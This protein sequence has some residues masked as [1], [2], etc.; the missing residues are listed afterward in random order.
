MQD[1]SDFEALIL[2]CEALAQRSPGAYRRRVALLAML[3]I[4]FVLVVLFGALGLGLGVIAAALIS[5][6][7]VLIKIAIFPL[8]VSYA[9][10]RALWMHIPP[11]EG[12]VVTKKTAPKLF[13][14]IKDVHNKLQTLNV[15]RVVI[16]PEAFNAAVVQIPR[17]GPLG[18]PKNHLII[19]L[20]L[21][22]ALPPEQFRAVLGHEFGHLSRSQSRFRTWIY[23][24]RQTWARLQG[25]GGALMGPFMRWY[26]PYFNAYS[27]VLARTNEYDADRAAADLTGAGTMAQAL[28]AVSVKGHYLEDGFWSD[29]MKRAATDPQPPPAPFSDY[30][31][32][33]R[34]LPPA[35]VDKGLRKALA[36]KTS[37][38]DTHPC[39]VD[40][41]QALGMTPAPP[42]P[43]R[44][45]AAEVLLGPV[46]DELIGQV[47][48]AWSQRLGP[49]WI[50]AHEKGVANAAKLQEYAAKA[51]TLDEQG[52]FEYAAQL[53]QAH[54][55][56]YVMPWL[57]AALARKP[58]F[59]PALFMHGRIRLQ[60]GDAGGVPEIEKAMQLDPDALEGGSRL[61]FSYFNGQRDIARCKPY[62]ETLQKF[63]QQR[64]EAQMERNHTLDGD[65]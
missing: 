12:H 8:A 49:K 33:A 43:L 20:P 39:L 47:N 28:T 3:G 56:E 63:E 40:R 32:S 7:V 5:K 64:F 29:L 34:N 2:K 15:H 25:E 9:L 10:L 21:L 61:L 30:L 17:L 51:E 44:A 46:R 6:H 14:E 41:L 58:E 52:M 23:R 11:P 48:A 24:S 36:E 54:H 57:E 37:L 27:F 19:G 53:E 45:S 16:A 60:D 35:V 42:A 59:A 65:T 4:T 13:A 1:L 26:G 62:L 38:S 55:G 50:E 22:E 31:M 18:W